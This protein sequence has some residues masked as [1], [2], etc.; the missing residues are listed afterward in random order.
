M[1]DRFTVTYWIAAASEAEARTRAEAVA[2]EQTLEIPRDAVPRGYIEDELLGRVTALVPHEGQQGGFR[3]EVS[4]SNDDV[5]GDFLQLL[6]IVFGNASILTGL[7]VIDIALNPELATLCGG[8]RFGAAGLRE[9][10]GAHGR[11]LFMSAI[12]PVGM[13]TAEL[14]D[15]AYQFALG[16]MDFVKDDH[17]LVDQ[18]TSPFSD[19]LAACVEAVEKANRETGGRASFVPNITAETSV[20]LARAEQ[21]QRAGAGAVMLAPGL[22]GFD[23]A[24]TL[25][26]SESFDLPIVTHPTFS[27]ASTITPTTGFSHRV[28]YGQ[29]TRMMGADAVVYPNFGGRFGFSEDEC[30]SI[31]TGCAE[32]FAGLKPVLP[33][34]GGG[35]NIE[36]VP[37]MREVYGHDVI[38]LV[39]GALL[40]A[41]EGI[42]EA[43]RRLVEAAS[44]A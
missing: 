33:T 17:G 20:A 24:R 14:A 32:D 37:A 6:N 29:M 39:G 38:Y 36:K 8:P 4:Y 31:A 27:G 41:P 15:R 12:K 16:G 10:A 34:P 22:M 43:A 42:T 19:R 11:P 7:R 23:V 30:R 5:G 21:A 13:S 3:A 18:A 9:R 2:L 26:R 40:R 1:A 44:A 28:F 35:M 25:A